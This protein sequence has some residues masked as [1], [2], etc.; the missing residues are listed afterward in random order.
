VS[1]KQPFGQH[2][3]ALR[4]ARGVTQDRL[5]E[6]SK[7]SADTIRR[8]E[9]GAFSPSLETLNKLCGGLGISLT[10]LFDSFELNDGRERKL[11]VDLVASRSVR[12][13]EMITRVVRTLVDELDAI[14]AAAGAEE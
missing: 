12:E 4:R 6:L 1:N 13:V 14:A 11:L 9:H 7:L 5:A 3:R 2:V 8:L 10:T